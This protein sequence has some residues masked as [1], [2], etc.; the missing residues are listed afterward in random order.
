LAALLAV[1]IVAGTPIVARATWNAV[2]LESSGVS[3]TAVVTGK[4]IN[5]SARSPDFC[6]LVYTFVDP[7]SG[8]TVLSSG[9]KD[10]QDWP[11][12]DRI[13]VGDPVAIMYLADD[14]SV[15]KLTGVHLDPALPAL[16]AV[17][18]VVDLAVLV[19]AFWQ[20][21]RWWLR[22]AALRVGL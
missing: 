9:G 1:G 19:W 10:C 7:A 5:T 14:P 4:D 8:H 17:C 22:R 3:T 15:N 12:Y 18:V 16:L 20:L 13:A 6:L 2:R 11:G 21:Y